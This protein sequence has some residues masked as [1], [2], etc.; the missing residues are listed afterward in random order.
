MPLSQRENLLRLWRRQGF[1]FAPTQFSLCP[2]LVEEFKRRYG[3][4]RVEEVFDT[5]FRGV[6]KSFLRQPKTAWLEYFPG[7]EFGPGVT[8]S[9]FGV[10][11]EPQE[12]SLH[13]TR[14]HHPMRGFDSLEQFQSYPYP[15]L[16]LD[17]MAEAKAG[18]AEHKRL[19]Y[20]STAGMACTIWE[21]A[22]YARGMEE[23]MVDMLSGDEK[24]TYH[25]DRVTALACQRAA[26]FAEAGAEHIHLG[27]DIGMQRTIMMSLELYREWLKP[28]LKQVVDAIR[29]V[30]PE[31]VVSYH[32]C[33]YVEPFIP[34]LIEV[35]VD[36]LNPV[37][38]ECMS[39]ERIHGEYGDRLSFWGTIGTQTTLPFGSPAEV[40][41][42]VLRNLET[43]G[44]KGGLLCAPTHLLEPEV[45]WENIEAYVQACR[46]FA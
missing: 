1:E 12:G 3:E 42:E 6:L 32:S 35:G 43:A 16:G 46:D 8:F 31:I 37:Q 24:A 9:P 21:T 38:P 34:D 26:A 2:S 45:P 36:V 18:V 33:G 40:R 13:M 29:K 41:A 19:G 22:W 4:R 20:L 39:F 44:A 25:L 15:T 5:P 27:D 11:H 23:L 30:N 10:G 14:M 17:D 28:R 7:T